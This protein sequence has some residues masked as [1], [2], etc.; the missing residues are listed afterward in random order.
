MNVE[1][2][3]ARS[4]DS[5][6]IVELIAGLGHAMLESDVRKRIEQLGRSDIPQIVAIADGAVVGFCGL[7]LM[8]VIYRP[9]PVGR[10]TIL[11]VAEAYRGRGVGR[12]L[13]NEAEVRLRGAG[14]GH[15]ELTSN[16]R[17]EEAH[18]FYRHLGFDQTSRRFARILN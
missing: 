15:M 10:I 18:A 9:K 13:V 17:L 6:K 12:A 16:E 8:T 5:A 2:R 11:A 4:E 14:C 3:E 1:I 7:H